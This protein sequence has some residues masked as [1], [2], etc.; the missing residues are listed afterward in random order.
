MLSLSD[1]RLPLTHWML[2]LSDCRLPL[3]HLSGDFRGFCVSA[4]PGAL[5]ALP[6][7]DSAVTLMGGTSLSR[8]V[9]PPC[10][11]PLGL[12]LPSPEGNTTLLKP[13]PWGIPP[14]PGR[15]QQ[16]LPEASP[17]PQQK[18]CIVLAV[19]GPGDSLGLVSMEAPAARGCRGGGDG[20]GSG[21]GSDPASCSCPPEPPPL[22]KPTWRACVRAS[23]SEPPV[24]LLRAK[25]AGLQELV[26]A[27]PD[28]AAAVRN[29]AVQGETDLKVAE[30]LRQ[31]RMT[32]MAQQQRRGGS[33]PQHSVPPPSPPLGEYCEGGEAMVA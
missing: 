30:A 21:G 17:R 27:H 4:A 33:G 12:Q 29:I 22:R 13:P 20:G 7:N 26:A 9:S 31:L 19:K 32:T 14:P 6:R 15:Q 23:R 28:L 10:V 18:K 16:Q 2:S 25:V 1:C 5:G 3:T 24:V 11:S 8:A